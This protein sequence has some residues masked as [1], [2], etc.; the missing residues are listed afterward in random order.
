MASKY[1]YPLL[2][3]PTF[4]QVEVRGMGSS[5]APAP[6]FTDLD[7]TFTFYGSICKI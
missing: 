3:V 4:Y 6:A 2:W 7:V 5:S 1:E